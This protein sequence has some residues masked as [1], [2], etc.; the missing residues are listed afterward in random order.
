MILAVAKTEFPRILSHL[1]RIWPED[2]KWTAAARVRLNWLV[3]EEC[4]NPSIKINTDIPKAQFKEVAERLA[5]YYSTPLRS[6]NIFRTGPS[7]TYDALKIRPG[8]TIPIVLNG[9]NTYAHVNTARRMRYRG[10]PRGLH[11]NIVVDTKDIP[12]ILERE[13]L[14]TCLYCGTEPGADEINCRAC[15]APLPPC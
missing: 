4:S 5:V 1:L 6:K 11:M 7:A 15:G 12:I 2:G 8:A 9:V 3:G 14:C 10:N 13:T